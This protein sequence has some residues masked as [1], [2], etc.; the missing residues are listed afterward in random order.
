[1]PWPSL[2]IVVDWW[3]LPIRESSGLALRRRHGATELLA[4]GD[5]ESC[6][7]VTQGH[8][9][10]LQG[11]PPVASFVDPGACRLTG[12][13][14]LTADAGHPSRWHDRQAARGEGLLLTNDGLLVA[15]EKRPAGL[16]AFVASPAADTSALAAATWWSLDD[17]L[18]DVSDI[19]LAR[20]E[21]ATCSA[22]SRSASLVSARFVPPVDG[23][24]S[25]APGCSTWKTPRPGAVGRHDSTGRRRPQG[26]K[27][28]S[29]GAHAARPGV[30][31]CSMSAALSR[32]RSAAR[33]RR[34]AS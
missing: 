32:G 16:L 24:G 21:G 13:F 17:D 31:M 9:V 20:M 28:E 3:G 1:M 27:K 34:A 30:R 23:P 2:A 26:A 18:E 15:R 12:Q 33:F 6:V 4:V 11:D 29:A 22:T 19:C 10:A 7:L 8:L 14:L 5:A 25:I